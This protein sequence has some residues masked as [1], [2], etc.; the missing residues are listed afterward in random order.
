MNTTRNSTINLT[1]YYQLFTLQLVLTTAQHLMCHLV[2][3]R[4]SHDIND[5]LSSPKSV[6]MLFVVCLMSDLQV[7]VKQFN[8]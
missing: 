3:S 8:P 1:I 4:G 2:P 6:Q 7:H 5:L